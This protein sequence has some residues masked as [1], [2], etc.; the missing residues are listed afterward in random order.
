MPEAHD[1]FMKVTL[2]SVVTLYRNTCIMQSVILILLFYA[3]QFIPV[4]Y[5]R[6]R[7]LGN[8]M[9]QGGP[10]CQRNTKSL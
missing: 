10:M 6:V 5:W 2:I 1:T 4:C 9:A 8:S 7:C 3:V